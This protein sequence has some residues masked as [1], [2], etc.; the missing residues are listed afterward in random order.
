MRSSH[1]SFLLPCLI[2]KRILLSHTIHKKQRKM[3][4]SFHYIQKYIQQKLCRKNYV[5]KRALRILSER[6]DVSEPVECRF[7]KILHFYFATF[8]IFIMQQT[9]QVP[10]C[11]CVVAL[12]DLSANRSHC[13]VFSPP[14]KQLTRSLSAFDGQ[15]QRSVLHPYGQDVRL[16]WRHYI[17]GEQK[18]HM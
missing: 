7:C 17:I 4:N 12:L 9:L 8:D 5:E 18:Q 10:H 6:N 16:I 2:G 11:A 14:S 13:S 3:I 15:N 1:R